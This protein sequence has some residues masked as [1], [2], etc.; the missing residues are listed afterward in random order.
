MIGE[1]DSPGA[2]GF[3]IPQEEGEYRLE[4]SASRAGVA[5]LSS[6]VSVAWTFRSSAAKTGLLPLSTIRF[7]PRLDGNTGRPL[8]VPVFLRDQHSDVDRQ[9]V[10]NAYQAG[11]GT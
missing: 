4:A 7:A 10:V 8:A 6:Q 3:E 5:R 1:N 2:G 9:T 11:Q